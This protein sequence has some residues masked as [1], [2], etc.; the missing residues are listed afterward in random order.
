MKQPI[1]KLLAI[2]MAFVVLISTMSFTVSEHY[3]GADFVSY[4]VFSNS[5]CGMDAHHNYTT[6]DDCSTQDTG[7][8]ANILKIFKSHENDFTKSNTEPQL[9]FN[10]S[11]YSYSNLFKGLTLNYIPFLNYNPPLLV[12]D[13]HVIHRVFRL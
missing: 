5:S 10:T 4:S 1:K 7:C 11:I 9:L 3:C 13:I 6:Q 2:C 12:N 8:C